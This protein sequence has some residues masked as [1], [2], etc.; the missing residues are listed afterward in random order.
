MRSIILSL[1]FFLPAAACGNGGGGSGDAD[2]DADGD[3]PIE[4]DQAADPDMDAPDE[5]DALPDI[6][7]DGE[8]IECDGNCHYVREGA[9]GSG[10][11]SDWANA[12]TALPEDLERGHIY[13][14]ASGDYPGCAFDD[15]ESADAWITVR[16]ATPAEHGTDAGWDE[17]FA[18]GAAVFNGTLTFSTGY[19]E[20]NGATGG[21]PGSWETG[22]GIKIM[23]ADSGTKNVRLEDGAGHVSFFHVDM[24]SSGLSTNDDNADIVYAASGNSHVTFSRCF[25]H[26][27]CRCHI[28]TRGADHVTLEYSKIARNGAVGDDIHREAISDTGSDNVIIRYNIFEDIMNTGFVVVLSSGCTDP[29]T[30]GEDA[31]D[32]EI[33]GNVF[34]RTDW[35][36]IGAGTIQVINCERAHRWKVYNNTFVDIH[37]LQAGVRL[38]NAS[39]DNEAMN[40]LWYAN[41]ANACV[42]QGGFVSD[43]NWFGDNVRSD[44][45]GT[46]SI[47]P[48]SEEH[49][50]ITTGD[51]FVDRAAGDF[52]LSAPTDPGMT[53]PP[54][55]NVDMFGRER[56]A[57]GVWDRGAIELE[58][59]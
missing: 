53:L 41:Q 31:D 29:S 7:P 54:P 16:K 34:R 8:P 2:A 36:S 45:P 12:W 49:T 55:Y 5:T 56:G 13:F 19:V 33:Y 26:D 6:V 52:G 50:Q 58:A 35:G 27:V 20:I 32:W 24:E 17:G 15:P 28:L 10:D 37:G 42:V 46:P 4:P 21:G 9:T 11:G 1:M 48:D 30:G 39:T 25:L 57:D 23:I 59:P 47:I 38:E 43:Y 14:I 18:S 40:N 22:F 3:A 44:D 51:P